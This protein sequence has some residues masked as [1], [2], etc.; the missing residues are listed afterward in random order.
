MRHLAQFHY[1]G[2]HWMTTKL[3]I[4]DSGKKMVFRYAKRIGCIGKIDD[5]LVH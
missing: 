3:P 4:Y 5:M 2:V 1:W